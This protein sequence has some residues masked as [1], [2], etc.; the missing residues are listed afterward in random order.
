M[1]MYYTLFNVHFGLLDEYVIVSLKYHVTGKFN[2]IAT[3]KSFLCFSN[4]LLA[5]N[6]CISTSAQYF[7]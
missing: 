4:N 7:T 3:I 1:Y 5:I 6:T 2:F